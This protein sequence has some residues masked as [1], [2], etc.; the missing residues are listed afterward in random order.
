MRRQRLLA[1][2]RMGLFGRQ[3]LKRKRNRL[4]YICFLV[5]LQKKGLAKMKHK[6]QKNV[7]SF[8]EW[9]VQKESEQ[10]ILVFRDKGGKFLETQH[11]LAILTHNFDIKI[12]SQVV[13]G[14][15]RWLLIEVSPMG[16]LDRETFERDPTAPAVCL[17]TE[18]KSTHPNTLFST[19]K[20]SRALM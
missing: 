3:A 15:Y 20:N 11:N 17:K 10:G 19:A 5:N 14:E 16:S 6:R 7:P 18:Y 2:R 4:T 12:D 9:S 8:G 13:D 1:E